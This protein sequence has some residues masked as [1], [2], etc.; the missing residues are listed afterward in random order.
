MKNINRRIYFIIFII[1]FSFSALLAETALKKTYSDYPIYETTLKNGLRVIIYV[2]SSA[3]IVSTQLWYNVGAIYDL[4]Y[5]SGMAHLLEHLN[6]SD[7]KHYTTHQVEAT[8]DSL[9]GED[10]AFT[11]SLYTCYWTD[12]SE[13]YYETALKFTS[14]H[15]VNLDI[16]VSKFLSERKVVSEERRLGENEPYDNMWEQFELLFY[17][18]HPY[19]NPIIGWMDDIQRIE[20]KDILNHYH[21][22]YQPSNAVCVLAGAV[23]PHEGLKKVEKYF[24][25]IKSKPVTHPN[26][27]E[28]EQAGEQ[29]MIIYQDVALPAIAIGYHTCDIYSPDFYALEVLEA[30]LSRGKDSR[31]YKKAVYSKQYA[32]DISAGD[33]L[34]RDNG[35]FYF[36]ATIKKTN[37]VDSTEQLIYKELVNIQS[38]GKDSITDEEMQRIKNQVIANEIFSKDS[39]RSMGFRLGRQAIATGNL[40]D[41]IEYPEKIE[42]VTKEQIRDVIGKYFVSQNRTVVTLLP[43]EKK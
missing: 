13:D 26:F 21:T 16:P 30:L 38:L 20:R 7:T 9:G 32:Q 25:N 23:E 15:M 14:D 3:P 40:A 24:G 34:E 8:I 5:K 37:L 11:S 36:F 22:Y 42:A 2:D 17:K 31:L 1:C 29:R 28:P 27:M 35:R 33:D 6:F 12:L 39:G 19:R 4:P 41:M 43:E 10:N 18:F